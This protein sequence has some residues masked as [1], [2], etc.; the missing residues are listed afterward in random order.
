MKKII[1]FILALLTTRAYT[2]VS[3]D[4]WRPLGGMTS[5][6]TN[7]I[8]CDSLNRIYVCT[9]GDGVLQSTD[10]G[11]TWHGFNKGLRVMPFHLLESSTI[12]SD[13]VAYVYG[14][15]Q[16]NEVMR[17]LFNV[18]ISDTHWE[19]LTKILKV[20][21]ST[22]SSTVLVNQLMTNRKGYLYLGT[23]NYGI[24][25]SRDHGD[26]FDQ[27]Q[28]L[29][30]PLPD[31]DIQC[32]AINRITQDIFA[33]TFKA[34]G[35]GNSGNY[36]I[37]IYRS[38]DDG[39]SWQKL[40]SVP[41]HPEYTNRICIADDGSII[42]GY[43]VNSFD[44]TKVYRSSDMGQ[45]W[46]SVL[47]GP[48]AKEVGVDAIFHSVQGHDLYVNRHGP[49]YL[50]TDN[51]AS[52]QLQFPDKMGEETFW[53]VSDLD[54]RIFQTAI[55]DGVFRSVD[56]ALH[57]VNVDT[58]LAVQHLDGG[59][60]VDSKSRV[61]S[62]SQFNSYRLDPGLNTAT[63]WFNF[64]FELDE[65]QFP[66]F[67]I[68]KED[69]VFYG[70]YWGLFRSQDL[71]DVVFDTVIKSHPELPLS[72]GGARVNQILY[73]G[74]NSK[75]EIFASCQKDPLG[76]T[77]PDGGP[78]FVRSRD[79]GDT[80]TRLNI[81]DNN[82]TL[83]I[84]KIDQ[85]GAFDFSKTDPNTIYASDVQAFSIWKST[86]DGDNWFV[87]CADSAVS[88]G[89]I[90]QIAC[91]PDGSVFRLQ[92]GGGGAPSDG[93]Y[94]STDGGHTWNKVFPLDTSIVIPDYSQVKPLLIDRLGRVV[95]CCYD[96][97]PGGVFP[98]N[99]S[100]NAGFWMSLDKNFTQWIQV[101]SG[102]VP[103]DWYTDRYLNCSQIA[104][105]PKTGYYYGNSRGR[106]VFKSNLPD[107]GIPDGVPRNNTVSA[108]TEPQNYPN[109]FAKTTAISFD[110]P[111]S[112]NVKVSVYDIMGRLIQVIENG[113]LEAGSH[114]VGFTGNVPNG[115]YMVLLQA[116]ADVISHWMTVTK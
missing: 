3:T 83:S 86:N 13:S 17:R 100:H 48:I 81:G 89:S 40:P 10:H 80:W 82:V 63:G 111:H 44:S 73:H 1:F 93:L 65:T 87:C 16:R 109:P 18:D 107:F 68:D 2:Q 115:Q 72:A 54:N 38:T 85:V 56:R 24:L 23:A 78:W 66:F 47:F 45:T 70:S 27:P 103:D 84:P 76:H 106:S 97:S 55:P 62:M 25:R 113:Y 29:K 92:G 74:V 94:H 102:F 59:V 30:S 19:Y 112:G 64:P 15:S 5:G 33:V 58:D 32:M 77:S 96:F 67:T 52:W 36:Q 98:D 53:C 9:G 37:N 75:D 46:D 14:T 101:S 11:S 49:T 20:D 50:S 79:H 28:N 8:T 108:L 43:K 7:N 51:G 88:E 35:H 110:L 61:F 26:T 57:F 95:I 31:S 116:G 4:Y 34:L 21:D 91:H 60:S 42:L 114:T 22:W 71:T 6:S 41:P 99:I 39:T 104:Q 105:D 90:Y 12:E 69:R